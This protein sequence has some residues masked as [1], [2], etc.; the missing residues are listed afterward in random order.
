M[1]ELKAHDT[2]I[3]KTIEML[4]G[5]LSELHGRNENV[6]KSLNVKRLD[7]SRKLRSIS[8]L[9]KEVEDKRKP[10]EDEETE[11]PAVGPAE[12][13]VIGEKKEDQ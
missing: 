1:K 5:I 13:E 6:M 4:E 11:T 12:P 8:D 10:E 7:R 9:K 2:R 3:T